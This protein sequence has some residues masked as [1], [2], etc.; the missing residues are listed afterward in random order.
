MGTN[1][2]N[3]SC[4]SS[5]APICTAVQPEGVLKDVQGAWIVAGTPVIEVYISASNV[6]WS[7]GAMAEITAN[8][9]TGQ[10]DLL[11]KNGR[12][13]GSGKMQDGALR[14]SDGSIWRRKPL[15]ASLE[16]EASA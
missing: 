10:F 4:G 3:L 8:S 11:G 13:N 7:N 5:C 6:L 2:V 16:A 1:L 14:W 9:K 15:E 12:L